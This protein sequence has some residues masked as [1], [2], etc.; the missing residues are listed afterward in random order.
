[1]HQLE[2]KQEFATHKSENAT[3]TTK[4]LVQLNSSVTSTG[5]NLAATP[6]AIKTAM[7]RVDGFF[8]QAN[9]RKTGIVP[10]IGSPA[11]D[12]AQMLPNRLFTYRA[13]E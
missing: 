13:T 3:I 7:D 2:T 10:A 1:M 5:E 9:N 8:Q 11:T 6:K 4:G 12:C